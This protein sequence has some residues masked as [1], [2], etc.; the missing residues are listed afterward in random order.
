MLV[1]TYVGYAEQRVSIG[2]SDNYLIELQSSSV[3]EEVIITGQGSGIAR[4]KLSTTVDVLIEQDIDKLP[5]N[6]IDQLLQLSTPSTNQTEFRTT[7]NSLK[8]GSNYK[9]AG[10]I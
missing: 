10:S 7:G 3:L 8:K 2:N 9:I 1:F 6:Q 5:A 4:R